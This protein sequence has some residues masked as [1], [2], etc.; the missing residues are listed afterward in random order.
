M[1]C[2]DGHTIGNDLVEM[3]VSIFSLEFI[4]DDVDCDLPMAVVPKSF[5]ECK[6]ALF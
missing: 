2:S 4:D 1:H 3:K 6:G 5:V